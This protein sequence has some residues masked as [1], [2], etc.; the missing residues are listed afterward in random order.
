MVMQAHKRELIDRLIGRMSDFPYD[1]NI[2][3]NKTEWDW[4]SGVGAYAIYRAWEATGNRGYIDYLQLWVDEHLPEAAGKRNVNTTAPFLG[5]LG[6]YEATKRDDYLQACMAAAEWLLHEA[7]YTREG[8][9]EHTVSGDAPRFRE[10]MWADTLFMACLFLGRF[11]ALTGNRAYMDAAARQLTIHLRYLRDDST[12]LFYHAWNCERG[13]WMSAARWGRAN[14]WIIAA[15][16]ELLDVLPVDFA[17]REETLAVIRRHADALAAVQRDN[18]MFGTLLDHPDAYDEA[19]A[20]AGI[21]YGIKRGIRRGYL[22]ARLAAV[23]DRA[24]A[25]VMQ[26]INA[27]GELE[28]VSHGTDVKRDLDAYKRVPLV[29]AYWG[30]GLALL[31]LCEE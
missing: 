13:D 26:R 19:S 12:G 6:L 29:P 14:A 5:V 22:P 9:L 15:A 25:A 17:G 1:G 20:T 30:Q 11:G 4:P 31:L 10:Q 24:E 27:R 7:P 21:A 28:Q 3:L 18:G 2:A 23:A 16:V 8:A